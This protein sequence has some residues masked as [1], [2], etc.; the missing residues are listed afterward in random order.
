MNEV[1]SP[2]EFVC[3][4]CGRY[5][6]EE[7]EIFPSSNNN[8]KAI[9]LPL[10]RK[11]LNACRDTGLTELIFLKPRV[12]FLFI[13]YVHKRFT[14]QDRF[15]IKIVLTPVTFH[16][17]ILIKTGAIRIFKKGYQEKDG[18]QSMLLCWFYVLEN[19][20]SVELTENKKE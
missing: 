20:I 13:N 19:F 12:N 14:G 10:R 16:L 17:F 2:N 4:W 5:V 3:V 11:F 18:Q 8:T 7:A 9:T 1:Y 6:C 15:S